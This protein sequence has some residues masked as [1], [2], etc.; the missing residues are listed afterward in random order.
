MTPPFQ[1][2]GAPVP[3][4]VV[5]IGA[6]MA[7][8]GA[9]G[10]GGTGPVGPQGYEGQMLGTVFAWPSVTPPAGS[11]ICDGS[12]QSRN[13]YANLF[14]L[15]GTTFG[16]GDG[17]TTFNLPDL[18]S[19]MIVGGGQGTGLT[20]RLLGVT[21]GEENHVLLVAE[22]ASHGHSISDPGHAHTLPAHG[23]GFND[24]GHNHGVSDPGHLHNIPYGINSW[25][26]TAGGTT[27]F[28]GLTGQN[29][30]TGASGTGISLG[31][32]GT[33]CSV[34]NAGAIGVSASGTGIGVQANGSNTG[35][36]NMPPFL[37]LTWCIKAAYGVPVGATIPLA[38]TTEPGLLCQV[39]GSASSY[40]GGDNA[41][42]PMP[43]VA[44][45]VLR[46]YIGG[47]TLSNT[48]PATMLSI[49]P[50]MATDNAVAITIA[51][52]AA[53]TK[54]ISGAWASGN[55][56]GGMGTGLTAAA[57]TWYHVFGI[58]NNGAFDVYFDTSVI[59]ANAPSGTTA[60]RRIG[61]IKLN[62][63]AQILGFNQFA[64]EFLWTTVVNELQSVTITNT[65]Y[66]LTLAGA[67]PGVRTQAR[68]E[69]YAGNTS[70]NTVFILLCT[71]PDMGIQVIDSPG[72]IHRSMQTNVSTPYVTQ[73]NVRTNA[74]AQIQLVAGTSTQTAVTYLTTI[75][76]FDDRG[77][78]N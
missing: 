3:G 74:S 50:G 42:H 56:N 12:A 55:G 53:F 78:N 47:F 63:S 31:A 40:I 9:Q 23:H 76:W 36:N 34:A 2:F 8:G 68:I 33:G 32:S 38:N 14:N 64:D 28:V 58:I 25:G 77:K 51:S 61:S 4:T 7:P 67:P 60:F 37:V 26:A 10:I 59:A 11:L 15:I 54:S 73:M 5:P 18:R 71:S 22:L 35:H 44:L 29:A 19:R 43:G 57:S 6:E 46:G 1:T 69:L 13:T 30:N 66:V 75:G 70:G 27:I 16:P 45:P 72:T 21:G 62:A 48:T 41:C 20:N 65:N 17:A 24:P 49:A 39:N 52:S